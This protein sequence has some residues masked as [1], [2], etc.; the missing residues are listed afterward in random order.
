MSRAKA[1]IIEQM[2]SAV[3]PITLVQMRTM[4]CPISQATQPAF[5]KTSWNGLK[6]D[7]SGYLQ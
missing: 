4:L 7:T 1:Y 6:E 3:G 5:R 2:G